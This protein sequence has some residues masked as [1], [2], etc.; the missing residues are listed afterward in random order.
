MRPI[1]ADV[2]TEMLEYHKKDC[3]PDH[4]DGHESFIDK[5]DAH[6]SYGEW[7]FANGFNLGIVASVVETKHA[8]TVNTEPVKH[9]CWI[10]ESQTKG[11]FKCS[12]CRHYLDFDGVNAGRGSANYCPNC[13]AKMDEGVD[14]NETN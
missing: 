12:V 6:D 14:E 4:F 9:G 10:G 13:G 7:Q 8:S 11:V 2:L 1:D 3:N 5:I